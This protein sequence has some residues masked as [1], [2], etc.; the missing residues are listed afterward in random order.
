[1][2]LIDADEFAVFS[3]KG[4]EGYA[5]CFD[6]GVIFTL[7]Q[8]DNAPTIDAVPVSELKVLRDWFYESDGITM[9]NLAML[10]KLIAKY[11]VSE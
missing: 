11:E 5:D 2:R 9:G 8:I 6:S 1:M 7:E 3:Y 10:N 4:T